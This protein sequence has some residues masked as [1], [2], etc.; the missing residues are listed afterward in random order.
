MIQKN[1]TNKKNKKPVWFLVIQKVQVEVESKL[2]LIF[3]K[4]N[5][6]QLNR[7]LKLYKIILLKKIYHRNHILKLICHKI[8]R[9]KFL[10]KLFL[11]NKNL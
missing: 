7:I 3:N 1:Q 8:A 9:L 5:K 6:N 2:M 11:T 10:K 4:I